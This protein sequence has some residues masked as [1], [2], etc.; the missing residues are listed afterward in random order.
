MKP[1]LKQLSIAWLVGA[2]FGLT[3]LGCVLGTGCGPGAREK[4][5]QTTVASLDAASKAFVSY[6]AQKQHQ[7]IQDAKDKPT[8]DAGLATWRA[9]QAKVE[10]MLAAGYRAAAVAQQLND[11]QSLSSMVQAAL[12]V[13]Q[14]LQA[15]KVLP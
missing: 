1:S 10:L 9:E 4:T 3:I 14:E 8:A 15:L 6:D 2:A 5:I 12:I 7:I 13:A 11:D